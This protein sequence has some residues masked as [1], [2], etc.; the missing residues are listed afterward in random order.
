M[1]EKIRQIANHKLFKALFIIIAVAFALSLRDFSGSSEN[2][3]L[4]VGE[5]KVT[6]DDFNKTKQQIVNAY[7]N[8]PIGN[9]QVEKMALYKS[10]TRA[11]LDQEIKS[12]GIVLQNE[13]IGD[14]VRSDQTFH[15]N[16]DFDFETYKRI[17]ADNNL[18]ESVLIK[19]ITNQVGTKFILDS[20]VA[21]MPLTK[22]IND[23]FYSYLT[24]K[25]EI[26]LVS[27]NTNELVFS[28]YEDKDLRGFYEKNPALFQ[29]KEKRDYSYVLISLDQVE[30]SIKFTDADLFKEYESNLNEYALPETRDFTNFLAPDEETATTLAADLTSN[31]NTEEVTKKYIEKKVI[32]ENFF[33]QAST[34]FVASIEPKLFEMNEEGISKPVKSELGWHVFKVLKIHPKLYKSFAQAKKEIEEKYRNKLAEQKIYELSKQLEDDLA[35]GLNLKEIANKHQL[36]FSEVKDASGNDP[37]TVIAFQTALNEDSNLTQIYNSQDYVIVRVDNII[38]SNP[39]PYEDAISRVREGYSIELKQTIATE[40]TKVLKETLMSEN[41]KLISNA[42]LNSV[43]I[44][45]KIKPICD[46][47]NI[48][49][50]KIKISLT[51]VELSRPT[52]SQNQ[53]IPPLMVENIFTIKVGETS[54]VQS[55]DTGKVAFAILNKVVTDSAKD[56]HIMKYAQNIGEDNYKNSLYDE[57]I[58]YLKT[59]Y[60]V[61]INYGLLKNKEE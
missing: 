42:S 51:N 30:K 41:Q 24:E 37:I 49:A 18:N 2:I 7:A 44:T 4:Q 39:I 10:I 22:V 6:I 55:I 1:L 53:N 56:E 32:A 11:L 59:K 43:E 38:P 20:I 26:S 35:S 40:L 50:D 60:P 5:E 3:V 16:G 61:K 46:K 28:S 58:E 45:Q 14:Y 15:K 29:T 17:L 13:T 12:F 34:S 23:Y 21:N 8:Q 27:V 25:R 9:E 36:T 33:N 52:I 57:Y 48:T 54:P 19:T 31:T 47:Y